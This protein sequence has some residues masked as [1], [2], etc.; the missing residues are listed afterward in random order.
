MAVKLNSNSGCWDVACSKRHPQTG[1]PV[2][3]K[4]VGF[5]SKAEALRAEQKILAEIQMRFAVTVSSS[6]ATLLDSFCKACEERGLLDRTVWNYRS[7]LEKHTQAWM[8]TPIDALT[9]ADVRQVIH[10]GMAHLSELQRKNV[11]KQIKAVFKFAVDEGKLSRNPSPQFKFRVGDKLK[12]VLTEDQARRFLNEAKLLGSP[13]YPHWAMALYTGMRNGELFALTWDKVNL[14]DRLITVDRAWNNKDGFKSTKSGDDRVL[15]IAPNL[16]LVLKQLRLWGAETGNFVLRRVPCW[17]K[18]EQARELRKFLLGLNLP[19]IR[20]HDLR[21]TWATL[22]LAKGV[23]PIKVMK[24]GGWQDM[25]TM[26]IYVRKAGVDI[27]GMTDRL[28]LHNPALDG[29]QVRSLREA[30]Q[31]HFG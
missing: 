25:K 20:F 23:E 7:G 1:I 10:V 13:W 21:A 30:S 19:P 4:R 17:E 29:G 3:L 2:T 14:E 31:L 11:A 12:G 26:M 15:E 5:K 28:D 22:L 18:G 16:C 27:R 8:N 9:P 6:W 24:M